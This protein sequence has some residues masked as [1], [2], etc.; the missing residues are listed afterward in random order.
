MVQFEFLWFSLR[1]P[2]KVVET[3]N[4]KVTTSV[5]MKTTMLDATLMGVTVVVKMSI[6]P[7]APTV[8]A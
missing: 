4:G 1:S 3:H 7:I 8:L 6:L 2:H 5:M